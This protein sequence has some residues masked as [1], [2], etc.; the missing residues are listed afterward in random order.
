M[1]VFDV[2]LDEI[3]EVVL[4]YLDVVG[5]EVVEFGLKLLE[6]FFEV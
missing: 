5:V 1:F 2:N 3:K 4:K 6:K